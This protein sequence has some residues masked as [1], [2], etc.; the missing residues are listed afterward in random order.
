MRLRIRLTIFALLVLPLLALIQSQ[1]TPAAAQA[2]S[3]CFPETGFC[4]SGRIREFW[5]QNGG[6]AVFGFPISAQG[7]FA[8]V[9]GGTVQ[10][11]WFER[12]RLE[13]HPQ[14]ARPYDV[15]LGRLGV[16]RLNQQG[17]DWFS[18][19]KA[20][21][22]SGNQPGCV[23]VARTQHSV[24]EPFSSYY[25]RYGLEFD[26][27]PG[28]SI[29]ESLALFGLPISEATPEIGSDGIE[30]LTQWFER[31]RLEY[32]PNLPAQFRVLGGLLGSEVIEASRT[33]PPPPS[34]TPIPPPTA[35]PGPGP[36]GCTLEMSF[37][38][39]VAVPNGSVLDPFAAFERVWRVR[40]DGTCTWSN[41][42]IIFSR[43]DQ[44]SGPAAVR[45]PEARPG[46]TIDISVPMI[47]P[48]RPGEYR[49]FWLLRASNGATF[50]GLVA[51]ITVRNIPTPTPG[52][53]AGGLAYTRW[54]VAS[55]NRNQF[56][57]PG[58]QLTLDFLSS[59][60]QGSSG[61][62]TFS[63]PFRVSS[64]LI[65]IGPLRSTL[66]A[67]DDARAAQ[68]ANY[69]TALQASSAWQREGTALVLFDAV[70][71]EVVRLLPVP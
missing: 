60:V 10:A 18:F 49:G 45:I 14:N 46:Q 26:G 13:L 23:F 16:D 37:D 24:C 22:E 9:E 53:E 21:P 40:N 42:Q 39:D 28:F 12:Q 29:E 19:P 41:Y 17:R 63:G 56:P 57:L 44:M 62:N 52:P 65:S 20:S 11:Q 50:G 3:R 51:A 32:H 4:I 48:G 34:P 69:L 31:A 6:L 59:E 5:E 33:P 27:R 43:G 58:D 2:G 36:G 7:P 55:L 8:T 70:G 67:C 35:I 30:R 15:L 61:C 71:N 64:S 68:E 25:Q 66:I 1:Q 47:A 38:R 54:V